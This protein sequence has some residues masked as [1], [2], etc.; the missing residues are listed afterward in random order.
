MATHT[1]L[2][3]SDI[4]KIAENY[5]LTVADFESIN[6]GN[7]NSSYLLTTP[8]G[9]YVLTVCDDKTLDE[10][11]I[12]GKLLLLLKE[13]NFPCTRVV[14]AVNRDIITMYENKPVMLKVYIEGQVVESLDQGMLSQVGVATARLNQIPSPDYLPDEH[15]YG[16]QLFPRVFSLNIDEK[17]QSW[18]AKQFDD[19]VQNIPLNLPRGLI[20]GDL[21]Y[22]NLIFE[23]GKFNAMID[24]EETCHY[25]KVF[26]L[27]MAIVGSCVDGSTVNLDKARAL[28]NGY[29]QVR[30]LEQIEKERY[31]Y[32]CNT[33]QRQR[34]T[35][36][37][38]NTILTHPTRIKQTTTGRWCSLQSR[39]S[40]FRQQ[41]F[42]I[43]F[44]IR[45]KCK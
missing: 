5:G 45:G 44:S 35:G 38:T 17:Y 40:V 23:Q 36:G 20:H 26:D 12:M 1:Q 11:V 13:Y 10:V 19:L 42:A 31:K 4:R 39:S 15:P 22:D 32:L 30:Q 33:P 29:Q 7:G 16:L 8:Q 43:Q 27:G 2:K 18:L 34:P 3:Q 9:K 41:G 6:G 21:F 25:Y 28:V 24:F 14:P 37:L